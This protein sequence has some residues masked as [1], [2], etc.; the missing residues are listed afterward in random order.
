MEWFEQAGFY[1]SFF[2]ALIAIC[3]VYISH[4]VY[5]DST[6]PEVIVYLEQN[7][8]DPFIID[9][10]IK[11]IGKGAA[12]DVTFKTSRPLP[13]QAYDD[14]A[15]SIMKDGPIVKGIPF[16]APNAERV[17][18]CG[19]YK[20]IYNYLEDGKIEVVSK[21]K[22]KHKFLWFTKHITSTSYIDIYSFENAD[23][24][25]NS[26]MGK[27]VKEL[28]EIKKAIGQLATQKRG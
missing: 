17:I 3:S 27:A 12:T 18:Q 24:S 26:K 11:N 6:S 14:A 28:A 23:A 13:Y 21:A 15:K 20:G 19:V 25:D 9:L 4:K 2:M 22:S 10:V 1:I 7:K 16:F 8:Q 5:V